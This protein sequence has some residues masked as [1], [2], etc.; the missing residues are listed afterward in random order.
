MTLAKEQQKHTGD[1]AQLV[2]VCKEA[3][4]VPTL[5]FWKGDY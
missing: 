1:S 5:C 4:P 2:T 3:D